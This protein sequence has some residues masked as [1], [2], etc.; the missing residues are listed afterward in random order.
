MPENRWTDTLLD[1]MRQIGDP[2]ADDAVRALF[3]KHDHAAV[4]GLMNTLLE[5]DAIVPEHLP[6]ELRSFFQAMECEVR[7]EMNRIADGECFFALHGP[8]VLLLLGLRSLPA[9]Y[10][11]R[12]GV[13]VL[14]ETG[15][16][17]QQPNRR[18][19]ETM[20]MVI[21]VMSP[22]GFAPEG[23]GL[24][25]V[26]K[27]RLM[28][29]AVRHLLL[30]NPKRPWPS[31]YGV[32]IN[33]EDLAGTLMTFSWVILEGMSLIGMEV[34]SE[35]QE[36]YLDA[37]RHVGCVLGVQRK[38]IPDNVAEA[39]QLTDIIHH[40]QLA[41]SDEGRLMT[42]A[43]LTMYERNTPTLLRGLPGAMMRRLLPAP[44]PDWLGIPNNRL[45]DCFAGL[46]LAAMADLDWLMDLSAYRQVVIRRF[47]LHMIQ[48]M[49]AVDRGGKRPKF[50]PPT[51]LHHTWGLRSGREEETFWQHL[52]TWWVRRSPFLS[53]LG[54]DDQR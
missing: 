45:D 27:V 22:G 14:Y 5:N 49:I 2:I 39:H 21:D 11:A 24:R 37:W 4:Q 12:K 9:A 28:H 13:R 52:F 43:L 32:P 53:W 3:K 10:A 44:V 7:T 41:P 17:R 54:V 36:A 20:Q 15:Y 38:L 47:S 30:H 8:E 42:Q 29:A 40:R 18:L 34:D 1:E 31:E 50:A 35:Q 19:F 6:D 23:R 16:L 33:Q 48:W 51:D 46:V 26:Q 25:T